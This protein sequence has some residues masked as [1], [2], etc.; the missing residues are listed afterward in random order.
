MLKRFK[1][2]EGSCSVK[3]THKEGSIKLGTWANAQRSNKDTL[4]PERIQRLEAI[5]FVWNARLTPTSDP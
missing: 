3:Q 5:G 1:E 2:R 4:T